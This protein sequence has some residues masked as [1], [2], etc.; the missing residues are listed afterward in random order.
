[1]RQLFPNELRLS[2]GFVVSSSA[3]AFRLRAR[4]VSLRVAEPSLSSL[5]AAEE[6]KKLGYSVLQAALPGEIAAEMLESFESDLASWAGDCDLDLETYLKVVNKWSHWNPRVASMCEEIA[7][8]LRPLVAEVLGSAAWPVGATIFRKSPLASRGTHAHQDL[9]YAWRPGSQLFSCTTWVALTP[10]KASPLEILPASHQDGIAPAVDFLDPSFQDRAD[11]VTWKE[12]AITVDVDAGDAILF[13]SRLWHSA[14]PAAHGSL[15]VALAITWATPAGPDGV[16]AG[17][18]PR[19]P[20]SAMPPPPVAPKDGFGMDTVGQQLKMALQSLLGNG[21]HNAAKASAKELIESILASGSIHQL[22]DPSA[23]EELLRKFLDMRKAVLKHGAAGQNGGLFEALYQKVILPVKQCKSEV[24]SAA[25]KELEECGSHANGVEQLKA[26]I[27][28]WAVRT[29]GVF[30]VV[31]FGSQASNEASPWSDVD[32][33]VLSAPNHAAQGL[34]TTLAKSLESECLKGEGVCFIQ[35]SEHKLFAMIPL[36]LDST[37]RQTKYLRLDCFVV[38]SFLDIRNYLASSEVLFDPLRCPDLI[39]YARDKD[40]LL[41]QLHS[42]QVPQLESVS[43][44]VV[45]F[46]TS[47]ENAASKMLTGDEYQAKGWAS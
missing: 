37:I 23:A 42:C 17:E 4:K 16:K 43:K 12:D 1:M 15:R 24:L 38:D 7:P 20:M 5:S 22:P 29:R 39:L 34:L 2:L 36:S 46:L 26:W 41:R 44:L 14:K 13:D 33:C 9:S 21:Q 18:Y 31:L 32:L 47:F 45:T 19:W 3:V 8:L 28:K 6:Y 25:S 10:A 40:E 11:S 27:G 30:G 35:A